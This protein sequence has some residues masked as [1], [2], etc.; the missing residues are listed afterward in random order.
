MRMQIALISDAFYFVPKY[1]N[2]VQNY[3]V[4]VRDKQ[5]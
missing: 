2:A 4:I 3:Q 1:K 5:Y